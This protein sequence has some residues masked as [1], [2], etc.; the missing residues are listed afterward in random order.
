MFRLHEIQDRDLIDW[1]NSLRK[2]ERS[3]FIRQ[4]LRK[5]LKEMEMD[6]K[7]IRSLT[8]IQTKKIIKTVPMNSPT[9]SEMESLNLDE[10]EMKLDRLANIF[11]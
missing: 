9:L 6:L 5:A 3:F 7:P 4:A 11:D 10:T 8:N 1:L 2:G